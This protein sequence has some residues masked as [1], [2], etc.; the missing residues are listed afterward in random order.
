MRTNTMHNIHI[1]RFELEICEGP[2]G[3]PSLRIIIDGVDLIERVRLVEQD[4]DAKVAG[5][6]AGPPMR[7]LLPCR[8]FLGEIPDNVNW[9]SSTTID[10]TVPILGCTCGTEGCWPLHVAIRIDESHNCVTWSGFVNPFR[11][12][13]TYEGLGPFSFQLDEYLRAL[14]QVTE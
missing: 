9:F 8:L 7:V 4:Y 10:G 2:Y 12:S 11:K 1:N 3:G 5:K 6:Y 14:E 13:W